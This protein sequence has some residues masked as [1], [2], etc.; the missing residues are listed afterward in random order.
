MH[1]LG[2]HRAIHAATNSTNNSPFV[3]TNLSNS[4]NFL[5]DESFLWPLVVID[6]QR[7]FSPTVAR[8]DDKT[9][10]SPI[11]ST[12]HYFQHE[13][14]DH[15][16]PPRR[17]CDLR[18]KLDTVDGLG[19]VRNSGE[20]C[21]FGLANDV[22]VGWNG[23]ELVSM[24]HPYLGVDFVINGPQRLAAAEFT[25]ISSSIPWNSASTATAPLFVTS[26]LAKPYSLWSQGATFPP[27]FQAISYMRLG[28]G[29]KRDL[30]DQ[31]V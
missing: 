27:R 20:W 9:H 30:N 8:S 7:F 3:S 6:W 4:T 10:H 13:I 16:F 31:R 1:E 26:T 28:V 17:V 2:R 23:G 18:V 29:Y 19:V 12:P 21:S 22:K 14:C 25:C 15:L 11:G 5:P 24:G